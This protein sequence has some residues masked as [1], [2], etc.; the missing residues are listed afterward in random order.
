MHT[1]DD[2]FSNVNISYLVNMTRHI[3]GTMAVLGD[4]ET[5][6]PRAYIGNPKRGELYFNDV[7]IA[8]LKFD[9]TIVLDKILIR[10]DIHIGNTPIRKVEYYYDGKL[11]HIDWEPPYMWWLNE[12]SF[13][14]HKVKIIAYDQNGNDS[15][16]EMRFLYLNVFKNR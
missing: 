3:A 8:D 7:S 1:P 4:I 16:D 15:T 13:R 2:D 11:K 9:K 12:T 6:V 10:P 5:P 14:R